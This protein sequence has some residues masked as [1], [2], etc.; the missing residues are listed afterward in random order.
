MLDDS[1]AASQRD[2]HWTARAMS[3][4][5]VSAMRIAFRFKLPTEYHAP[6]M[7]V[8]KCVSSLTPYQIVVSSCQK[9][10]NSRNR[11]HHNGKSCFVKI[12]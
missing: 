11:I 12:D 5:H 4:A 7:V 1:H 6:F 3:A 8:C 10:A 9:Q 2:P